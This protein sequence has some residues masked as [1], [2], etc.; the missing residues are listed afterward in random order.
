MDLCLA[1][2]FMASSDINLNKKELVRLMYSIKA[3]QIDSY[4]YLET[5][6][7][8]IQ[9]KNDDIIHCMIP[10]MEYIP[11]SYHGEIVPNSWLAWLQRRLYP[12]LQKRM[13]SKVESIDHLR[14]NYDKEVSHVEGELPDPAA[15]T[16]G[17][18]II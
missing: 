16:K 6:Y 17:D 7:I 8:A 14:M 2:L 3:H 11:R 1:V 12:D 15:A 13:I 18:P 9:A 10:K 4:S 5:L